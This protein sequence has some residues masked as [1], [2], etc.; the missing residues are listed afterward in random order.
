GM[1]NPY[2]YATGDPINHT[3]P[4]G[5]SPEDAWN[6]FQGSWFNR[7]V[8][9]WQGMPYVDVALAGIGIAATTIASGGTMTIPV[10]IAIGAAVATAGAAADQI[11][12]HTTGQ[13]FLPD[14]VRTGFNIAALAGG[15]TGAAVGVKKGP[16]AARNIATKFSTWREAKTIKSTIPRNAEK[17][18]ALAR[19]H[20]IKDFNSKT[21]IIKSLREE[22]IDDA[23]VI[24]YRIKSGKYNAFSRQDRNMHY[25][26][27]LEDSRLVG[28]KIKVDAAAESMESWGNPKAFSD[29]P[30]IA[31]IKPIGSEVRVGRLSQSVLDR[32]DEFYFSD[33]VDF[34][35]TS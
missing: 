2:T 11:A 14:D 4:T 3:D 24:D 16:Q 25:A 32:G 7:E 9:G 28:R 8:L 19:K 30:D 22:G 31:I 5:Q 33:S 13:G 17:N 21:P 18:P 34:D 35:P 10:A 1:L 29:V 26:R 15:I 12:A 23:T 20:R 27:V 6:W